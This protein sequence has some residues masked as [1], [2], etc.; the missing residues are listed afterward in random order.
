MFAQGRRKERRIVKRRTREWWAKEKGSLP[1]FPRKPRVKGDERRHVEKCS[2][3]FYPS[4]RIQVLIH[5]DSWR[6]IH[7]RQTEKR[8]FCSLLSLCNLFETGKKSK[9]T[10]IA[11]CL[12]DCPLTSLAMRSISLLWKGKERPVGNDAAGIRIPFPSSLSH[13]LR[14][15]W[16]QDTSTII[17]SQVKRRRED[18][19]LLSRCWHRYG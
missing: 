4:F 3:L 15:T 8:A 9:S 10:A 12:P 2:S 14:H 17:F 5:T 11:Y 19:K 7:P 16:W 6:N 1:F 18:G 13:Q